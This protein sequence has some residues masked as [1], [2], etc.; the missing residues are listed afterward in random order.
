MHGMSGMYGLFECMYVFVFVY[1]HVH[2]KV[3]VCAYLDLHLALFS[4]HSNFRLDLR[5]F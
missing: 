1:V 5:S 4:A 2:V 3:Y